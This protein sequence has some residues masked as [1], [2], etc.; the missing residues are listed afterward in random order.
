MAEKVKVSREVLKAFCRMANYQR[1]NKEKIAKK[2]ISDRHT[3]NGELKP[4]SEIDFD[5]LIGLLY[6]NYELIPEER[7]LEIYQAFSQRP[8]KYDLGFT[9]GMKCVLDALDKKIKGVNE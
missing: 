1:Q 9:E 8:S 6:G 3:W 4:L 5:T 7:I 2:W